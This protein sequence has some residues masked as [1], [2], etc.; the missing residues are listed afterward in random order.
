MRRLLLPGLAIV[1]ALA[2][3]R[4]GESTLGEIYRDSLTPFRGEYSSGTDCRTLTGKVVV[5]YQGWFR[6]EGDG[7]GLG[8]VHYGAGSFEPGHC[9]IDLWPD[10]RE[11][12]P[13]ERFPT[14]FRHADG[15]VAEVFSPVQPG[16]VDLHFE[17][18]RQYGIDAAFVQR[19]ASVAR[20]RRHLPSLNKVLLNVRAAANAKG[21]AYAVM[22]DLSGLLPEHFSS[23]REDW[24]QLVRFAGVS[25]DP[26]DHAYLFH[27]DKPLVALW[28][29]GFNDREPGF[30]EWE[31]LLRFFRDDPEYGGCAIM[32]GVPA[33]W[34]QGNRDAVS[35]SRLQKLLDL[36]DV[37]SPW[38]VGRYATPEQA[39]NHGEKTWAQDVIWCRERGKE[40]LPVAFPGFS[41]HNLSLARGREA[42]INAIP[43]RG[44]RFLWSQGRAAKAAG[45]GMLYVAMFDEIDEGTA[46]FKCL[47]EPPVGASSFVNGEG[48]PEDH[49]LWLTGQLGRLMRGDLRDS[50]E[51][52]RRP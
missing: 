41:W 34:R 46:I 51:I 39:A 33:Y 38:T 8:W 44:G 23:V 28:G 9:T 45:A 11:L 31:K 43:R 5:G 6:A 36:A 14:A 20:D 4:A 40:L 2:Q 29:L 30:E 42:A 7:S 48:L 37:I 10:V 1:M 17:W 15:R 16:T 50:S 47:S 13:T 21:R 24:R 35:D 49:Y 18:M 19:F 32:V 12:P 3:L 26:A 25:R 52:P 22:Y 27:R